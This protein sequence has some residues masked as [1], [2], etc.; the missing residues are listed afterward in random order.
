MFSHFADCFQIWVLLFGVLSD[1][2]KT[3]YQE[4]HKK[5]EEERAFLIVH[6]KEQHR[7]ARNR[8]VV[9]V[10]RNTGIPG[11]ASKNKNLIARADADSEAAPRSPQTTPHDDKN[12]K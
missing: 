4:M 7:R 8:T 6:T 11:K 5:V 3:K 1:V 10:S 2:S 9:T 12:K